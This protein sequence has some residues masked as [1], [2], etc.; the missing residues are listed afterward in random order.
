MK[1]RGFIILDI[2]TVELFDIV[3]LVVILDF[4]L[5]SIQFLSYICTIFLVS[6]LYLQIIS[7]NI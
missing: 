5:S 4:V 3:P 6:C 7:Y 2:Y 1:Q